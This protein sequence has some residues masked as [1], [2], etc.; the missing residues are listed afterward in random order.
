MR[1]LIL[2]AALALPSA[3]S[4]QQ[5]LVTRDG[6]PCLP[7]ATLVDGKGSK[8]AIRKLGEM[9]GASQILAVYRTVDKCPE[10]VVLRSGIGAAQK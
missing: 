5:R 10:P 9:P 4:A 7:S 6:K 3:A 2:I 1:H 8:P